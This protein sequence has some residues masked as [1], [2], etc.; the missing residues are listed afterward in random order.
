MKTY[1][2]LKNLHTPACLNLHYGTAKQKPKMKRLQR[3]WNLPKLVT[4]TILIIFNF[5]HIFSF[6]ILPFFCW[7]K[8][9]FLKNALWGNLQYTSAWGMMRR[10]WGDFYLETWVKINVSMFVYYFVDPDPLLKYYFKKRGQQNG[11]VGFEIRDIG[12]SAVYFYFILFCFMFF[13][14]KKWICVLTYQFSSF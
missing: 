9:S 2:K 10:T 13:L 5:S 12:T 7:R 6:I 14:D 11:G 1:V 8:K 3:W 4:N